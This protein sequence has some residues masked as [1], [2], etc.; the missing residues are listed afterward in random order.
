[1]YIQYH[2]VSVKLVDEKSGLEAEGLQGLKAWQPHVGKLLGSREAGGLG[3][4]ADATVFSCRRETQGE[5]PLFPIY[6]RS[7]PNLMK[8]N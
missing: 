2:P 8:Y 6:L 3:L 1:M 5:G 4:E 7:R